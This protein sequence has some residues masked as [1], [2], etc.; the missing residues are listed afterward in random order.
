VLAEVEL[1]NEDETFVL[2]DWVGA[3]VSGDKRFGYEGLSGLS[4]WPTSSGAKA[5]V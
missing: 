5:A 2:P 3:E 4:G 1:E